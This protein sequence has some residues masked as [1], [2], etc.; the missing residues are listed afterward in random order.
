MNLKR[1]YGHLDEDGTNKIEDD[2]KKYMKMSRLN[3][4]FFEE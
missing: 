2:F 3:N 1:I 4:D